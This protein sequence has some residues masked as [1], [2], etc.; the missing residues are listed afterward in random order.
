MIHHAIR[1]AHHGATSV[2][3]WF[4]AGAIGGAGTA[5]GKRL[6]DKGLDAAEAKP[7]KK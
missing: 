2:W 7:E 6:T 1:S 4:A 5:V 3:G